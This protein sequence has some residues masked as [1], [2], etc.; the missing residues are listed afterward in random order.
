M[1]PQRIRLKN[2][3]DL[4]PFGRNKHAASAVEEQMIA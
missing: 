4:A 3:S 1:R 2:Q